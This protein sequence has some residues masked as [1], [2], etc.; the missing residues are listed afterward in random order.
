L[1][2]VRAASR[3]DKAYIGRRDCGHPKAKKEAAAV[4]SEHEDARDGI[5]SS[6]R[7]GKPAQSAAES[8]LVRRLTEGPME[9]PDAAEAAVRRLS[10][11]WEIR[12]RAERDPVAEETAAY[13]RIAE[14]VDGRYDRKQTDSES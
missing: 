5:S 6:E 8:E 1:R 2:F 14:E 13:R 12:V 11:R 9:E 3:E 7:E 10:P 4:A